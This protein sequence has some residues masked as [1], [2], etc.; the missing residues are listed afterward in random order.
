MKLSSNFGAYISCFPLMRDG[1]E[2][3]TAS[4]LNL[5]FSFCWEN[6]NSVALKYHSSPQVL[7]VYTKRH[8]KV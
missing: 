4:S 3:I 6:E 8:F 5:S 2:A 1:T 7:K